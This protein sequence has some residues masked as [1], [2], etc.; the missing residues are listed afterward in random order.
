M[1][2]ILSILF[3]FISFFIFT[4]SQPR[5]Q[6]KKIVIDEQQPINGPLFKAAETILLKGEVNG[7]VFLVGSD[8]SV[9]A[10][11]NGDLVIV[12]VK[13]D[14][15]GKI[16]NDF[17]AIAA[18][19]DVDALIE[20]D[21]TLAGGQITLDQNTHVNNTIFA[22]G[23]LIEI[24]GQAD[25]YIWLQSSRAI[26]NGQAN[27]DVTIIA[28]DVDIY[29]DASVSGNLTINSVQNPSISN[30][31]VIV[32][33]LIK[34]KLSKPPSNKITD[35]FN[36]NNFTLTKKLTFLVLAQKLASLIFDILIGLLLIA[37]LP[38]LAQ[39]LTKTTIDKSSQALGWGFL[40]L[41][42]VP[43]IALFF[44]ISLIGIPLAVLIFF[45]YGLFLYFA[46]L[47]IFLT[48]G[49]KIFSD[50]KFKKPY[51]SLIMGAII[52]TLLKLIPVI[53]SLIYA[54]LIVL[55]LGSIALKEKT[56]L[57]KIKRK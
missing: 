10:V 29:S 35:R 28:D 1:K 44:A 43:L 19:I 51:Q 14:V 33:E 26:F 8:I 23:G 3:I 7:D 5:E 46:K 37:L 32:G 24:N 17:R 56:A 41:L 11:I 22:L 55:G 47:I 20:D 38:K 42:A 31:A 57:K 48:I 52:I 4:G 53:G 25:K 54:V 13:V 16:T 36:L 12:G 39:E 2:K 15:K 30:K 9:D 18:Q 50:Y 34:N 21:I 27:Q 6:V 40:K 49:T 45:L